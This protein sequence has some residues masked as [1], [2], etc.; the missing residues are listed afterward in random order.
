MSG[1]TAHALGGGIMDHAAP[2]LAI[3]SLGRGD[4]REFALGRKITRV[5]HFQRFQELLCDKLFEWNFADTLNDLPEQKE[6][7]IA[8]KERCAGRALQFLIAS[9][10]DCCSPAM[11][12]GL[13][14]DVPPQPRGMC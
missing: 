3:N 10:R 1:N 5:L 6:I 13:C 12:I 2:R 4:A 8:V 9:F 11:P 14:L 7:D